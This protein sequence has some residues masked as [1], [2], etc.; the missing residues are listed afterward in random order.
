MTTVVCIAEGCKHN[1]NRI[2]QLDKIMI[3][4]YHANALECRSFEL[5]EHLKHT[6]GQEV[7]GYD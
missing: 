6:E 3:G 2:C 4:A 5:L 1:K 7:K